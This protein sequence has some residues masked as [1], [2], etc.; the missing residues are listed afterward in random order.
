MAPFPDQNK[1]TRA[2][3]LRKLGKYLLGIAIGFVLL[4]FFQ[5]MR[6]AEAARRQAEAQSAANGQSNLFPPPPG[7]PPPSPDQ[8]QQDQ[9]AVGR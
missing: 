1:Q 3:F 7:S 2:Q 6:Q 9:P 8:V 5:R 4:G